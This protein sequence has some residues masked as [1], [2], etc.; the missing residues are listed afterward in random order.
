MAINWFRLICLLG[1]FYS[2][3]HHN[4][5]KTVLIQELTKWTLRSENSSLETSVPRM[6]SGVYTALKDFYGD[7]LD[8]GNDVALRWIANQSWIFSTKFD[9]AEMGHE[10]VNLTL[11]GID[12]VSQVRV[13]GQLLGETD[14]M[15]VRYS[16]A[17][18]HLLLPS[19]N[20]NI[21]EVEILSPIQEASRRFRELEKEGVF[22]GPPSCPR[23]RGDVECHRNYL[24]KMQMSFGGEWN[25]VALSSG[26]WKPVAVE[27]YTVAVLRDVDVAIKRNKTYWTLDC[28]AFLDTT[29]SKDFYVD[30]KAYA[31]DLLDKP[32][33]LENQLVSFTS[34]VLEFQISIP[35]DR[36]T[37]WWPN[38][39][40]KQML[41][42]I[43][44][45]V[46]CYT[47]DAVPNLSSRTES[48]K[49]LKV[50]FRTLELVENTDQSGR[51]F[52]FRVNG[53][54]IFT[55]GANYIPAHTLPELSAETESVEY[56]LKAAHQANMNMIRVWGGGLY[57]SE[58]FY[59]LADFYGL[60]V[61][62]DM[63]F[64]RA[65]YPLEKDFVASVCL[66][67][68]QNAQR[69]SY[70][71]SLA[72]IAANNEIELFLVTNKS[73]FGEG[74][75]RIEND[76][77]A[78][79]DT[80][81]GELSI[82]SRNDFSPRPGPMISTPSLG[83]APYADDMPTNPQDPNY[84]DV[85]L[86]V[87]DK[88]GFSP[89]TYPHARFVSEFGYASLPM[90]STWQRAL[91]GGSNVS[92]EEI[93][94]L[95]RSRQHDIKGFI[96]MLQQ[97]SYQLPFTPQNWDENIEKFIY[98]SQVAQ[99]MATKTAIELFRS[100]RTGNQTMGALI[101]Q[102]NDV[103]VAPTWSCIDFY[104]N[105]KLIYYWAKEFL[106][107]KCVI[108]LYDAS[109]NNLNI[110]LTREDYADHLDSQFYNVL[111][112]TY[113]WTD[114]IAKKT[115]AR[116]FGLGSNQ[117]EVRPIPLE[118]LLYE[119]H[120]KEEIFL[121]I[122]LEDK[123]KETVA[124]NYYYPVPMKNISGIKD[125]ELTVQVAGQDCN[126]AQSPY[127]NSFSLLVTVRFPA[128]LVY[129]E[130][131]HPDYITKRHTFSINGFTQTEPRKTV[132][133]LFEDDSEC[134]T[135]TSDDIK[136]Q[137]INQYLLQNN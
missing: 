1:V 53:H 135:L 133:L 87:D 102:L 39:Y 2:T 82:I 48:Q 95:I 104:G 80:I 110:T 88:D 38:G 13:N 59:N 40:G 107:S 62:Q 4:D 32:F 51:T 19:P 120:S 116:A 103:W 119:N 131:V 55:K 130:L 37:M 28:R 12:T 117:L 97:I 36:V 89:E 86:W 73:D 127:T 84:G 123:D 132:Y 27:Y 42:P 8:P 23:A 83:V 9:S 74:A 24:R 7:L 54:P 96:P 6:P 30:L 46:K 121:E 71:P 31:S 77:N 11:H 115:I 90:L 44:F 106:A 108:A 41:Y 5:A 81:M 65:A 91:G 134:L 125:P 69:L 101:W 25:P 58:N 100:L 118:L 137:T 72:L 109:S 129:L 126:N 18:G 35:E 114:L 21:L 52:F 105:F 50:G 61:W 57:E 128:L 17:I 111:I 92:N 112:N 76:Y 45:K 64:S 20:Q 26:I 75:N 136:V 68:A 3:I 99:A 49:I 29:A 15:F 66:E 94:S 16:F 93:A 43:L 63:A 47:S 56:L 113:L 78:L 33:V 70:H 14:N 85:H 10:M 22:T 124:R 60:L 67:T 122:V 79:F 98:F 34:P